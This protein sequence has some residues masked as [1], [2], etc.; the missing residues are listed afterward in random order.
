MSRLSAAGGLE[1]G[2]HRMITNLVDVTPKQ[3]HWDQALLIHQIP[4]DIL[5]MGPQRDVLCVLAAWG[6][7][8]V[9]QAA[10]NGRWNLWIESPR[11]ERV[12]VQDWVTRT[13]K[14]YR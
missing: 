2:T 10:G 8:E 14:Q 7:V 12:S 11:H 9:Y 13:A 5:P 1:K 4:L 6:E 3:P